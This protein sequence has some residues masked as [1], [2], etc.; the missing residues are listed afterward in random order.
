MDSYN[1]VL[2]HFLAASSLH[3][4]KR[5]VLAIGLVRETNLSCY[6]QFSGSLSRTLM[7]FFRA[8]WRLSLPFSLIFTVICMAFRLRIRVEI[9]IQL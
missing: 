4:G 5:A 7:F 2:Q 8:A 9:D 6:A 3:V 1:Q